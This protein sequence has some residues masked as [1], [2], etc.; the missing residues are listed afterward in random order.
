LTRMAALAHGPMHLGSAV[1]VEGDAQFDDVV[2]VYYPG[3][4]YFSHLVRSR[5]FQGIIGDKQL[6]DTLVVLTVPILSRLGA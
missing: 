2:I 4:D 5:F 6:G 1:P 3:V